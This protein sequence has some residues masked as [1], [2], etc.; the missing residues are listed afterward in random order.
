L[1]L[2]SVGLKSGS[3]L[4]QVRAVE[5]AEVAMDAGEQV[6]NEILRMQLEQ[7]GMKVDSK[8]L[9]IERSEPREAQAGKLEELF[10]NHR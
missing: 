6:T 10:T 4:V 3:K 1:D 7:K 2:D 9:T 5:V 8:G